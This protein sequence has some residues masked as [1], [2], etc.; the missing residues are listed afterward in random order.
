MLEHLENSRLCARTER[1]QGALNL[2]LAFMLQHLA[3]CVHKHKCSFCVDSNNL[4]IL[5]DLKTLPSVTFP[6]LAADTKD[7]A[8][9][10][11]R[12]MRQFN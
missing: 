4:H 2:M 12:T 8:R 3:H 9:L 7:E 6:M 10:R 11:Q 5:N 1:E